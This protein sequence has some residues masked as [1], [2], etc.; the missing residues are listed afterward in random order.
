VRFGRT[1]CCVL[2]ICVAILLGLT[3]GFY[4]AFLGLNPNSQGGLIALYCISAIVLLIIC[5]VG[6][7]GAC[8]ICYPVFLLMWCIGM[9]LLTAVLIV[10]IILQA[11]QNCT[12]ASGTVQS[13]VCNGTQG[14]AALTWAGLGVTLGLAVCGNW[15][16]FCFFLPFVTRV[17]TRRVRPYLWYLLV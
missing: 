5:V 17:S 11:T 15:C 2:V 9:V 6:I 3:Q 1:F 4:W 8:N 16:C 13:I 10:Q 12:A 7:L 14:Y